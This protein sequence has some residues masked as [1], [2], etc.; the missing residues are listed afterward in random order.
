MAARRGWISALVKKVEVLDIAIFIK[1]SISSRDGDLRGAGMAWTS[2]FAAAK[3]RGGRFT[4]DLGC[5]MDTG[6]ALLDIL[7]S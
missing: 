6:L 2:F 4:A 3:K 5:G 7:M 1:K